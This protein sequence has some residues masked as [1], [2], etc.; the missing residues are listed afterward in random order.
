MAEPSL[1]GALID[2]GLIGEHALRE[3][4][5]T[6]LRRHVHLI[7]VLVDEH[8]VDEAELADA[9]ARCTNLPRA[10]IGTVDDEAVHE[11][12]HDVA[13]AY[14]VIPT[15]V[16][17]EPRALRLAMVDPT[18]SHALEDIASSTDCA[19]HVEVAT[20][21][22]VRAALPRFYSGM[23]TRMIPR[24][25]ETSRGESTKPHVELPDERSPELL[26]RALVELLAEKGLVSRAEYDERVQKL[27][28]GEDL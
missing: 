3:A 6:A 4:K 11:V 1:E 16:T 20:L 18:D 7:E 15:A 23:I 22:D 21:S 10:S 14:L 5:R 13:A 17:H 24:V 26:V 28:R 25:G 12:R 19:I 8:I 9:L 27:T 2:E